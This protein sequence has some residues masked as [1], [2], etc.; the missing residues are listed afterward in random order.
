MPSNNQLHK[1]DASQVQMAQS[2]TTV[3][4]SIGS[5]VFQHEWNLVNIPGLPPYLVLDIRNQYSDGNHRYYLCC[6]M[7]H[8]M[9]GGGILYV[10]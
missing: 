5:M 10:K 1:K 6:L 2:L 8:Y 9:V 4:T 3:A 7:L